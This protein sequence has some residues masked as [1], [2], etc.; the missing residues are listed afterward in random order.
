MKAVLESLSDLPEAL[1]AEYEEK[2]GK[3]VLKLE[4]E[5]SGYVKASQLAEANARLVEFRDNNR[6]LKAQVDQLMVKYDGIDPDEHKTLKEKIAELEKRGVKGGDDLS[7]VVQ[8][9]IA[10]YHEKAVTPLQ[11]Q[12]EEIS[13][14]EKKANDALARKDLESMLTKA[15]LNAGIGEKA[16]PDY[17][18]RGLETFRLE[19]GKPVARNGETPLYSKI[20]QTEPLSIEEWAVELSAEAPHLFKP[21]H[22]GSSDS[23]PGGTGDQTTYDRNDDADFLK[24]VEKIAKGELSSKE[25]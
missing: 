18:R 17:L 3:Y 6:G 12:L 1:R 9:A 14:R 7:S 25:T 22:G 11:K 5:P 4:G 21:S 24:N 10:D 16:I 20:K 19:D 23:G 15:G 13:E 2:D 8:K